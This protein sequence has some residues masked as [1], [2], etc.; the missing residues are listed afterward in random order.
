MD[1]ITTTLDDNPYES[2]R[3]NGDKAK[4]DH[5]IFWRVTKVLLGIAAVLVVIDVCLSGFMEWS[6]TT[7]PGENGQQI[8]DMIGDMKDS[9]W[10]K[11]Q[12]VVQKL[13]D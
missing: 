3:R 4:Y 5:S 7:P 1:T 6:R 13:R 12:E 11:V 2:P 10:E 9:T 8:G